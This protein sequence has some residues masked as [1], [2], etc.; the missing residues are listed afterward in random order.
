[1]KLSG[2]VERVDLGPGVFVLKGD[3]GKSYQLA[4]GDR[5]LRKPGQRV[6]VEGDVDGSAVTAAMVGP[7][8][9]VKS[10]KPL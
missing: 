8:L 5:A 1:M 4:G 10:F 3:D 6:E 9:R 2:T 7:V